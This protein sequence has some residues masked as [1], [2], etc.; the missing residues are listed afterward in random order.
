MKIYEFDA[1][2]GSFIDSVSKTAGTPTDV[3]FKRTEKGTA[4]VL[5]GTTS[6]ID[7]GLT[8]AQAPLT[9]DV[10]AVLW[11]T[12]NLKNTTQRILSNHS[13]SAVG[14]QLIFSASDNKFIFYRRAGAA[15][16]NNNIYEIGK[17]FCLV[18][19]SSSTG[20]TNFY[21]NGVNQTSSTAAGTPIAG[22]QNLL[23]GSLQGSLNMMG[24]LIHKVSISDHLFTND[25]IHK[26][27]QEFLQSG[28]TEKP[29]RNFEYPKPTDLSYEDGLVAA[30]S[31][32]KDTVQ[33]GQLLDISGNGNHGT[34][35]GAM[36]TKDG[37]K[38]DGVD[39]WINCGN[40]TSLRT[41]NNLTILTRIKADLP[42]TGSYSKIGGRFDSGNNKRVWWMVSESAVSRKLDVRLF[43]LGISVKL[44]QYIS[45]IDVFDNLEHTVGFT[46]KD[47]ILKIYIDGVEDTAV[48]K[49]NDGTITTLF[50]T[51]IPLTLGTTQSSGAPNEHLNGEI[52]D[53]RQYGRVLND[54]EIKDYHNS[55]IT[56]QLIEDFSNHPVGDTSPKGWQ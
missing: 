39:D 49:F 41:T 18:I 10:T 14:Y 31:P 51:D 33:G 50:D 30:Y 9:G 32:S 38:F 29:T 11:L 6:F 37:M 22:N 45:S 52:I 53:F 24:G 44:K 3:E 48:A 20:V 15:V 26:E 7:T 2:K 40:D 19:T 4:A 16:S 8:T 23:I 36:L 43:P 17:P 34:I 27:Y 1:R 55:F 25:E 47:N 46:F 56:P 21:V 42:K 54:Q 28:I 5:N 13:T 35:S 12:A